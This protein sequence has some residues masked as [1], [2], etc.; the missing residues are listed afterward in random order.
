MVNSSNFL[1]LWALVYCL[2]NK[3]VWIPKKFVLQCDLLK[4]SLYFWVYGPLVIVQWNVSC[5]PHCIRDYDFNSYQM[6]ILVQSKNTIYYLPNAHPI[7]ELE[8]GIL[9]LGY[10]DRVALLT[11]VSFYATE[12]L[13]ALDLTVRSHIL[14]VIHNEP[15]QH[16]FHTGNKSKNRLDHLQ[17]HCVAK[18]SNTT[19]W[20][21]ASWKAASKPFLF[22]IDFCI[23]ASGGCCVCV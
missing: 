16:P 1:P 20:S 4:M 9:S 5:F 3:W 11:F 7:W 6:K 13:C 17:V 10:L 23:L 18:K 2:C 15:H 12:I 19:S 8:A 22:S 14:T 21:P